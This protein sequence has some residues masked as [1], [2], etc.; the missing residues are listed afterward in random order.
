MKFKKVGAVVGALALAAGLGVATASTAHAAVDPVVTITNADA[1]GMVPD[2]NYMAEIAGC[3]AAD[4]AASYEVFLYHYASGGAT[5]KLDSGAAPATGVIS[6]QGYTPLPGEYS[7]DVEC[8]SYAGQATGAYRWADFESNQGIVDIAGPEG[9]E[10][11]NVAEPVNL[12]S[13]EFDGPYGLVTAFDPNSSVVI[14]VIGPDGTRY[15]LGTFT[16]NSVGTLEITQQ[17]PYGIDGIY[18]VYAEGVKTTEGG[19][20]QAVTVNV[21]LYNEYQRVTPEAPAAPPAPP[22][23]PGGKPTALPKTGS[24]G[25]GL[26]PAAALI[27]VVAGGFAVALRSRKH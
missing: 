12:T 19:T 22:A 9:G 4:G 27:S 25:M 6:V 7:I 14:Y 3:S 23:A 13:Y 16:A 5:I 8:Y 15:D 17:L 24:E 1:A 2:G 10:T 18:K 26:V 20:P 21:L 11:F